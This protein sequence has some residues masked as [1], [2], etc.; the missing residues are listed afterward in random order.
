MVVGSHLGAGER[1]AVGKYAA[2]NR[3][4]AAVGL[5]WLRRSCARRE[6]LPAD[7]RFAVPAAALADVR[8][9]DPGAVLATGG[10]GSF[11]AALGASAAGGAGC[12]PGGGSGPAAVAV[13]LARQQS[14]APAGFLDSCY[15]TLAAVRGTAEEAAA[16]RVIRAHGGRTFNASLPTRAATGSA[17]AFAI[18]PPSLTP[19][20]A[21]AVRSAHPDFGAVPESGRF[22]LYWLEC[23]AEAG[24]VLSPQRGSPC[25][26][27]LPYPLPLP[28]MDR[29]S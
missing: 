2:D 1:Q 15:F 11:A 9:R 21:A 12:D 19:T 24:K 6:A 10:S 29:V 3:Q 13:A 8:R 16:E 14:G 22:T 23:C 26:T 25:Y 7:E 18:C 27:P 28:G 17:R 4:A 5:E 20:A